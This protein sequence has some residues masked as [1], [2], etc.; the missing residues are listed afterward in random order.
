M[1]IALDGEMTYADNDLPVEAEFCRWENDASNTIR[2]FLRTNSTNTGRVEFRQLES[3]TTD[4]V[5]SAEDAYSPG[6][7]VPF[8]F[9]SRHT[10]SDLNGAV[11][12]TALT[13]NTTVTALPDLSATDFQIAYTGVINIKSLRILGG[14]GATDAELE[15]ATT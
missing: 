14:Y 6:I 12:G 4:S 5:T 10:S 11:D 13:A 2:S 1:T 7:N 9:A 3:G 8:N 15:A